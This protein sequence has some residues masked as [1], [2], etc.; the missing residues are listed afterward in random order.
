M[1]KTCMT[2]N[3]MWIDGEQVTLSETME[4]YNPA[5]G[6]V[7]AVVPNGGETEAKLA[8]DAAYRAFPAWSKRTAGDRA[9]YL[10]QWADRIMDHQEELAILLSNEQGKPLAEARGEI[11]GTAYIIRYNAEEGQ[12]LTGEILPASN[13][14]QKLMVFREP[15]GVVGLITPAN[16][17][18]AILAQKVAPALVAG[19]TFVLKPAEQTPCIAIALFRHLM[20]TG[21][22]QGVANLVT[23]DPTAIGGVLSEDSR[24]RKIS[25]TGSTEVGKILMRQAADNVKRLTLEL[26]G[27]APAIVFPDADLD[28]AADKIVSNKFENA[29][30]VCNGINLIYAHK[31]IRQALVD[32]L[33]ARIGQLNVAPGIAPDSHVGAMIDPSYLAKVER[34]VDDAVAKGA[35]VLVGGQRLK[36]E[37]LEEG[38][39]FAPTLLDEVTHDM[40]LTQEEIFGPVAPVL[41]FEDEADVLERSNNTPYGLAA[42]VFTRD[43]ARTFRMI[44]GLEVGNLAINGT[45]LAYPQAPFGGVKA[46]GIGRVGG[47]HG[48][49]EFTE[50][51]YVALTFE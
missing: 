46:S 1:K 29:G 27:N 51:K 35:K 8:V 9:G 3:H 33:A 15:V 36:L 43:T 39:Y 37:G 20:E 2:W 42:Y 47:K 5:T 50:L 31:E 6:A 30:Q 22:P 17:P 11:A 41:V 26:G 4:V 14:G 49:E 10:H 21:I 38:L 48:V 25:F 12:R 16:F 34:L 40:A 44:E 13:P 45:S 7:L 24:V 23:G 18:G 32:K 28:L 19:C